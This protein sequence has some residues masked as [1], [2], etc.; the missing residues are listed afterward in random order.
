MPLAGGQVKP[1]VII[2]LGGKAAEGR[3]TPRRWRGDRRFPNRAQLGLGIGHQPVARDIAE[4]KIPVDKLETALLGS[5]Q[6]QVSG[7][8]IRE[9]GWLS[10]RS[11]LL[12]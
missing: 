5:N 10:F 1:K 3:R 4:V 6:T 7:G 11:S 12:S 8:E 2:T 9:T